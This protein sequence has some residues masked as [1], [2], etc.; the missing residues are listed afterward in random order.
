MQWQNIPA[1]TGT[2]VQYDT[3]RGLTITFGGDPALYS[4]ASVELAQAR[5]HLRRSRISL[6][7]PTQ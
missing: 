5:L 2:P 3:G 6:Q 1:A 7:A 4:E